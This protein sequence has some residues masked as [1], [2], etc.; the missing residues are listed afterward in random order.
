MSFQ[1]G[2]TG[3]LNDTN[4][5]VSSNNARIVDSSN[6]SGNQV[7]T[8]TEISYVTL[9]QPS[10]KSL[11][12]TVKDF[13]IFHF[14][15]F[16]NYK[17]KSGKGGFAQMASIINRAKESEPNT[18]VTFGG[19]MWGSGTYS[20]LDNGAHLV[21]FVNALGI[22][23][24][25]LGNHEFDFGFTNAKNLIEQCNF[26]WICSNVTDLND[27]EFTW[28]RHNH[29][30]TI[31]GVKIGFF[32]LLDM[33]TVTKA[34]SGADGF[35]SN[36]KMIDPL[37][38]AQTQINILNDSSHNCDM[39]VC[40]SHLDYHTNY[41]DDVTY[42]SNRTLVKGFPKSIDIILAASNHS[43]YGKRIDPK[44][45]YM[46]PT[47]GDSVEAFEFQ[48]G[49]DGANLAEIDV[50]YDTDSGY[51]WAVD[52][53]WKIHQVKNIVKDPSML[54]LEVSTD[55]TFSTLLQNPVV[56]TN[57]ALSTIRAEVRGQETIFGNLICD[58]MKSFLSADIALTN[59]GGIRGDKTYSPGY[60]LTN[61]DLLT[62]LPFGNVGVKLQITGTVL[63]QVIEHGLK[64][65]FNSGG[66][67]QL[68]G[69][70]V[71][72]DPSRNIVDGTL[73]VNGLAVVDSQNYTVATNNY[74][75]YGGDSY[76][77]LVGATELIG[78]Q[79]SK[80]TYLIFEEYLKATYSGGID[81]T[82]RNY[83]TLQ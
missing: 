9:I 81:A 25:C 80:T 57:V 24:A 33:E 41:S 78:A 63:K 55:A 47:F 68:S 72:L 77:M 10:L 58:S 70:T 54:A 62:E 6:V 76:S 43:S 56:V 31:N 23:V 82:L 83:I 38:A 4:I 28:C 19:D 50:F 66:Y 7:T 27:Q 79:A 18:F 53:A 45:D 5:I 22:E 46:D 17:G 73:L 64:T 69:I 15:D 52:C 21:S 40:L 2:I 32:A 26:P 49:E 8:I 34:M 3:N 42:G 71:T 60:T 30:K 11:P 13:K 67:S 39:I 36:V 74:L 61:A 16:Y 59:G 12:E 1:I 65:K 14:N 44:I 35:A 48:A 29:V 51:N 37:I 20:S 75:Q